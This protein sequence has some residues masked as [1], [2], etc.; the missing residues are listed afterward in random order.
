[1]HQPHRHG[2]TPLRV[3]AT[4]VLALLASVPVACGGGEE[5]AAGGGDEQAAF[6]E[7]AD[8]ICV[9][10][11]E[12]FVE[13]TRDPVTSP[14]EGKALDADVLELGDEARARMAQLQP[15]AE[16]ES[17]FDAYLSAED[18]LR[19]ANEELAEAF[20]QNDE[21]KIEDQL[22][23]VEKLEDEVNAAAAELG[24]TAC[25]GEL[26]D[27]EAVEVGS[28]ARE[29]L[30]STDPTICS[31]LATDKLIEEGYGGR[32]ENCEREVEERHPP[33]EM[34]TSDVS[35]VGPSATADVQRNG[36]TLDVFLI[37]DEDGWKVD[38]VNPG[39]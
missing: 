27:E 19:A 38:V 35:G 9:D 8:A 30:T 6:E 14:A 39:A 17:E 21:A 10:A 16:L 28:T 33:S 24:L 31:E 22:E 36:E 13:L 3:A 23:R 18:E 32:V 4:L 11:A 29:F 15:P 2:R 25:A 20:A 26:P 12:S 34:T 5:E 1:M 37:K 7:Q